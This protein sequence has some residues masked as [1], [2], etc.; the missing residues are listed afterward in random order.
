[1]HMESNNIVD[2]QRVRSN[3]INEGDGNS[4]YFYVCIKTRKPTNTILAL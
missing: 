1:M 4:I 2:F 3:Q